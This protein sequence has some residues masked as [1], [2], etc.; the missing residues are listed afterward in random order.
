M[1]SPAALYPYVVTWLVALGVCRHATAAR[2]LAFLV[3]A[4]LVGQSLRPAVLLRTWLSP[5]PVPARQGFKRLA[6]AFDRP[7]LA[8]A[9]LAP[10][11]V[12]AALALVPRTDVT[13]LA[14]D[15]VRC[16]AWEVL[17]IGVV[18]DKRVLPVGWA[19]LPYP[20]PK[21]R[22][23]PT[24]CALIR[25]VAASWPAA[26]PVHLLA[27]RGFPSRDL[28]RT[29]GAVGWGWTVRLGARSLVTVDGHERWA[30]DLVATAKAGC[31]QDY[32]TATYG[33][34]TPCVPG[35]LAVG[36]DLT[37]LPAHQAN[38]SSLAH[39]SHRRQQRLAQI[40][41]KHQA[42][43]GG[44]GDAA[45]TDGWVILFTTHPTAR[46]AAA[47]Y[48]LR[49]PIESSFRDA[50]SGGDGRAGWDLERTLQRVSEAGRVERI[51]GLWALGTLLQTWVGAATTTAILPEAIAAEVASWTTTGRLSIWMRGRLALTD[52][53]GRLAAWLGERLTAGAVLVAAAP[54]VRARPVPLPTAS[55]ARART[56]RATSAIATGDPLAA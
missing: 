12:R 15:G 2:S 43:R 50:Q 25:E 26:R 9:H 45:A 42:K 35:R 6:R 22:L 14:L 19:V 21:R 33:S 31:W 51:V 41:R 28:F 37:V 52:R 5:T 55:P 4:L 17:V 49:W 38:P 32:P 7:W 48:R 18:W 53:R 54:P 40:G 47:S 36:K 10:C 46:A 27:D 13:H 11:L 1:L 3:T 20:W 16:G 24:A 39:R 56:R 23:R 8:S 44:K 30:K 34:A 29:L